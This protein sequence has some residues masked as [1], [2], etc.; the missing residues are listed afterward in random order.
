MYAAGSVRTVTTAGT[1]FPGPPPIHG[2]AWPVIGVTDLERS[3]DF[4]CGVLGCRAAVDQP[5]DENERSRS[6]DH[7][8]GGADDRSHGA[9]H[10]SQGADHRSGGAGDVRRRSS[11]PE[12]VLLE[13]GG[14]ALMLELVPNPEP[15]EWVNDDLQRG[16]RHVA[17]KVDDL[18]HWAGRVRAAGATFTMEPRDAFGGVRIAFFLDPDGAHLELV[19]GCV[20]YTRVVSPD[21][22]ARERTLPAPSTPRLDHVALSVADLS[23]TLLFY[24]RGAGAEIIGELAAGDDPRG[25][26]ITYLQA[27]PAVL[28]IFSFDLPLRP[29]PWHPGWPT[30]GLLRVALAFDDAERA[31][32]ALLDAGGSRPAAEGPEACPGPGRLRDPDVV[33]DPDGTPLELA[34]VGAGRSHTL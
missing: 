18:E 34:G 5:G 20:G 10:R 9:D 26:R 24:R 16:L 11:H 8:S 28:E 13:A 32:A 23:T 19:Q 14:R 17:F 7:R 22:V 30:A 12:R 27:G 15:H 25:F 3:L 33:L 21:L 29:N 4:Y 6:A 1:G 31:A 2:I